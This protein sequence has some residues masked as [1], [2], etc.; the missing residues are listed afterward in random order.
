MDPAICV[1]M[2]M[3]FL[4]PAYVKTFPGTFIWGFILRLQIGV[5]T[6]FFVFH[7]KNLKDPWA[8]FF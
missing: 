3:L 1:I 2:H 5:G 4:H 6:P 7:L 8:E